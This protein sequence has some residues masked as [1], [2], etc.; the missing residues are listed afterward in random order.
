MRKTKKFP[1]MQEDY[2]SLEQNDMNLEES[3]INLGVDLED[4]VIQALLSFFYH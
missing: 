2:L 1:L 3:I 4:K